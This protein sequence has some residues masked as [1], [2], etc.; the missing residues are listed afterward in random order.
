MKKDIILNNNK[1]GSKKWID[2]T[3]ENEA[4]IQGNRKLNGKYKT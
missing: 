2:T 1:A 4:S 3:N